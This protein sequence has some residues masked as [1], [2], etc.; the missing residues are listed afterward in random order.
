MPHWNDLLNPA[1]ERA[2]PQDIV[3][4]SYRPGRGD[5]WEALFGDGQWHRIQVLAWM[6][7]R[8]GRDVVQAAWHAEGGTY[9]AMYLADPERMRAVLDAPPGWSPW[10]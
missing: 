7:T 2:H 8:D 3:P 1:L 6:T 4:G 10:G 9:T 5:I